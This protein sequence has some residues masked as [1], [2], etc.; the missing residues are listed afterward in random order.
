MAF[1]GRSVA[2]DRGPKIRIYLIVVAVAGLFIWMV[3]DIYKSITEPLPKTTNQRPNRMLTNGSSGK[4]A[5]ETIEKDAGKLIKGE[6]LAPSAASVQTPAVVTTKGWRDSNNLPA[7]SVEKSPS[8][9][10][11]ETNK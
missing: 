2:S 6:I 11:S 10:Y 3:W 8:D 9:Y 5:V 7:G 1:P 4:R